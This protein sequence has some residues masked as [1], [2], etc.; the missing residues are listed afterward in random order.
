[1]EPQGSIFKF[2]SRRYVSLILQLGSCGG[3]GGAVA[4]YTVLHALGLMCKMGMCVAGFDRC[5][6]IA[7]GLY[8]ENVVEL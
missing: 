8:S 3:D 6:M 4:N 5:V 1:M 2:G 7:A